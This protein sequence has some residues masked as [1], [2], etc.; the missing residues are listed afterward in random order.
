MLLTAV[1]VPGTL[2]PIMSAEKALLECL[3]SVGLPE[4]D[5]IHLTQEIE[6]CQSS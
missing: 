4:P 2:D 1:S 6:S 5:C 3:D